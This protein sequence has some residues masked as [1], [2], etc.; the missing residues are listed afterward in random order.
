MADIVYCASCRVAIP[1]DAP[2][3]LCPACLFQLAIAVP[4][5]GSRAPSEAEPASE[6]VPGTG[7]GSRPRPGGENLKGRDHARTARISNYEVLEELGRGGMGVVFKARQPHADRVV[8]LKVI[9]GTGTVDSHLHGRLITEARALARLSHPNIVQVFEVGEEGT[10]FFS[11][12][13]VE[14]G[15]LAERIRRDGSLEPGAAADLVRVLAGAVGAAHDA[16][17]LHRDLKP[18]NVL[19]KAD[20]TP[21]VADFGLAKWLSGGSGPT[22]GGAILGT[23]SYMA[24]E[25]AAGRVSDVGPWTDVYALGA[26]LYETLTGVPPFRADTALATAT[27]V[28]GTEPVAPRKRRPALPAQLEAICLKCL[29]KRPGGRYS[30]ARALADDLDRWRRGE[31]TVA[32]PLSWVRRAWRVVRPRSVVAAL[33]TALLA[34][35]TGHLITQYPTDP[36]A[37]TKRYTRELTA[38]R[39]VTLVNK[40]GPPAWSRWAEGQGQLTTS[41]EYSEVL[42]VE[43]TSLA[44]LELLPDPGCDRY[45]ITAEILVERFG[46]KLV[47]SGVYFGRQS[48]G[49]PGG[50]E[51]VCFFAACLE[52]S[53]DRPG[54]HW[55]EGALVAV[56]GLVWAPGT[57]AKKA[58]AVNQL[59]GRS[60]IRSDRWRE[61]TIEI[62]P[63][64]VRVLFGE[65]GGAPVE[66][67][68]CPV[69]KLTKRAT[70][71]SRETLD[72]ITQ[73]NGT[74]LWSWVPRAPIGVLI[75]NGA[76]AVRNVSV[77]PM[78]LNNP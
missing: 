60:P 30:T 40:T 68:V 11:M 35:V 14:G 9:R 28:T 36:D 46:D 21:K 76:I 19:L 27:L 63:E 1:T 39:S 12:E 44:L 71:S 16:G 67:A 43:A 58:G 18:A 31:S 50:A 17:I 72:R 6:W 5:P 38:G 15:T 3:G 66:A 42:R 51:C 2:H 57:G 34:T 13:Y 53:L 25:Q 32:R 54:G 45:R 59:P 70:K 73:S 55:S 74:I 7:S 49:G 20:G 4:G 22:T 75:E 29:E 65:S 64:R 47:R 61:L 8:A 56:E 78:S 37:V 24:P 23:P 62:A 48:F 41:A 10:P 52:D 26:I 33:S 77:E 69:D